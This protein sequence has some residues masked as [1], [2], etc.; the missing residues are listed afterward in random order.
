[1]S[2]KW[3]DNDYHPY[4]D[5]YYPLS[6]HYGGPG[7]AGL[8]KKTGIKGLIVHITD[9]NSLLSSL[10]TTWEN[11]AAS[12]HFAVDKGGTIAQYIPL[13]QRSWAVDGWKVDNLWYSVENV[14][15]HG[16]T[17]TDMQIRM[18]GYLL[19]WLNGEYGVPLKLAATPDDSGLSYHAMFTKSK[20]C[21]GKP[22][23]AQLQDI[24]DAAVGLNGG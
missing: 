19:A 13:S 20:P 2:S 1:M 23:I 9:G 24:V 22:V 8:M 11:R 15:V 17:L 3:N 4:A 16:E 7:A 12:A 14:A 6:K 18:N 5:E 21:P 10:K